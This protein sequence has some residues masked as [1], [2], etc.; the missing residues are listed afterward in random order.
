[1]HYMWNVGE[2]QG[3]RIGVAQGLG[4]LPANDGDEGA[5]HHSECGGV[6]TGTPLHGVRA[7]MHQVK[8]FKYLSRHLVS[9]N[10]HNPAMRHNLRKARC[11]WMHIM[12]VLDKDRVPA[13]V[14]SMF[15]QAVIVAVLLYG[16]ELWCLSSLALDVLEGFHVEAAGWITGMRPKKRDKTWVYPKSATVL[17]VARLRTV[18]EYITIQRQRDHVCQT[19]SK[20]VSEG[21]EEVRA[22]HRP[23]W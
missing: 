15:Y 20:G 9:D 17:E 1:M 19:R 7:E 16:L 18:G 11:V 12:R 10:Q 14:G 6:S 21:G 3:G 13:P 2:H 4:R 5:A 23:M 22:A 8:V